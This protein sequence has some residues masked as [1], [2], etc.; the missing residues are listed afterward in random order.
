M[1]VA[2][3]LNFVTLG[4]SD[5]AR[6]RQFYEQGLGWTVSTAS[7]GDIVFFQLGGIVLALYPRDL[8]AEDATVAAQGSGFGGFT[9]AQN[10][11]QK[12]EVATVL[13]IAEAAGGQ[14]VKPAQDTFWGGHSGYFADPDGNLWEVAWNP[15]LSLN[16]LGEIALP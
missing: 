5:L 2:A 1:P 3:Q 16:A 6:S 12:S 4:V 9:L 8:L 15:H 13:S 11:R 10:V 7:K 14:I